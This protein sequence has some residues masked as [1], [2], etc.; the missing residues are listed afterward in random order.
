MREIKFRAWDADNDNM[1]NLVGL[2]PEGVVYSIP[3]RGESFDNFNYYTNCALMQYTGLKDKNSREIYESDVLDVES[4]RY[5][6]D[7]N[8]TG[9]VKM[10][11]GSWVIEDLEGTDGEYLFN[12]TPEQ[13]IIGNIYENPELLEVES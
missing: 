3:G 4:E 13:E 8:R 7:K 2:T 9:V 5:P 1:V 10:I 11:D 6:F 12:E